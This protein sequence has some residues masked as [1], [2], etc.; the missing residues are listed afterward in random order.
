M[1]TNTLAERPDVQ[2]WRRALLVMIIVSLLCAPVSWID[3]G[4]TPSWVVYPIA[5]II[6]L[7]RFRSGHG[8]LFVAIA[9]L[10]FLIVHLPWSWAAITGAENNPLDRASPSSPVQWLI[11]L[12]I[13]PL[14]TTAIGWITWFK[15]R[16]TPAVSARRPTR[17]L[18]SG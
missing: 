5:L 1:L 12:S 10:V 7:W 8:A 15:Q 16:S 9:S 11:T 6:A 3:D 13:V 14:L 17:R 2:P 18:T 4:I